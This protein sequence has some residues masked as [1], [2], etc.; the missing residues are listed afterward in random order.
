MLLVIRILLIIFIFICICIFGSIYCLFSPRNPSHAAILSRF[1]CRMTPIFG[2]K[3]EVRQSLKNKLPANCIYIANHQNNYD[4]FTCTYAVQ[5]RTITVGKRSLLW[6]PLFGLLYWLTGNFFI[7]RRNMT[8]SYNDIVQIACGI[9][10]NNISLWIFPEGTRSRGRG[11]LPF[12]TSA[13]YAAI[14]AGL[15]IVPVCVSNLVN[16]I[17]LNRWHNGLI[18]IEILTPVEMNIYSISQVRMVTKYF[19]N[20]MKIKIDELNAEVMVRK[21]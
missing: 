1:F 12:K 14:I 3:V 15:P 5:P 7:D 6:I 17:K 2:I 11:L 13:F 9:K 19:Y 8:R 18:I 4:L 20:L 21:S 16:K 10:K